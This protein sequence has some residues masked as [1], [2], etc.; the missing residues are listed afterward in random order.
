[1]SVKVRRQ[2]FRHYDRLVSQLSVASKALIGTHPPFLSGLWCVAFP[3]RFG[4]VNMHEEADT[5]KDVL[6]SL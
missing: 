4:M 1:M 6:R 3:Q 5:N 2:L